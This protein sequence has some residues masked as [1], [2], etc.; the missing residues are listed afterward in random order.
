[1]LARAAGYDAGFAM[2][3][4][5]KALRTNPRTAA[6]LDAIREWETARAARAYSPAQAQ[7]LKDPKR[8]FHLE[9]LGAGEWRLHEAVSAVQATPIV[10]TIRARRR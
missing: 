6:L 1:M 3:A 5:P 2:V 7:R 8:A 9:P 4:R 10:E